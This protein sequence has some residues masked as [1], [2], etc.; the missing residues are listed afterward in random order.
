MVFDACSH[1]RGSDEDMVALVTNSAA[2][3]MA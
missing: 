3:A 2:S 1:L